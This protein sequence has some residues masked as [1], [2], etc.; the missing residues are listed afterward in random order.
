MTKILTVLTVLFVSTNP[1]FA[2]SITKEVKE[3]AVLLPTTVV[4]SV[5]GFM[6][7]DDIVLQDSCPVGFDCGGMEVGV[8]LDES[9]I[10]SRGAIEKATEGHAAWRGEVGAC[11]E[12]FTCGGSPVVDTGYVL[13][14]GLRAGTFI[15][16]MN[17]TF[18]GLDRCPTCREGNPI[19][20][21]VVG[22]GEPVAYAA[23]AGLEYI[24]WKGTY[25]LKKRGKWY[26]WVPSVAISM[27]HSFAAISNG[28]K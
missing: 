1:V 9:S 6:L 21:P 5:P 26:W 14:N 27:L 20:A 12:G 28:R 3:A 15:W 16:D 11:A 23:L 22:A 7:E 19:L 10:T 18:S 17:S 8:G 13:V 4:E 24:S 25:N 2:G